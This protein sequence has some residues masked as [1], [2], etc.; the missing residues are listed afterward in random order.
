[1]RFEGRS[2]GRRTLSKPAASRRLRRPILTNAWSKTF[3]NSG[4]RKG[5]LVNQKRQNCKS[6]HVK[7]CQAKLLISKESSSA[8]TRK[9]HLQVEVCA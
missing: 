3:A 1:M 4:A 2:F 7:T 6:N 8:V 5:E 9:S